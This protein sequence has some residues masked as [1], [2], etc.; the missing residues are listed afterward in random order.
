MV[1]LVNFLT[2]N[3]YFFIA[4]CFGWSIGAFSWLYWK[5]MK[6]GLFPKQDPTSILFE[7]KTASGRSHKNWYTKLGGAQNCLRIL[8]TPKEL[9]I[10]PIFPFSALG[11]VFDLDH[12]IKRSDILSIESGSIWFR[13]SAIVTYRDDAGVSLK[14]E[15]VPKN[16][17]TF[18][19][20]SKQP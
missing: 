7:E 14:V 17:E 11:G 6:R 10:T 19:E 8:L 5:R 18:L 9:W 4:L 16:L 20:I 13:K 12:R 2:E 3:F 15:V 1:E